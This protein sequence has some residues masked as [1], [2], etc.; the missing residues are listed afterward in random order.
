MLIKYTGGLNYINKYDDND[1]LLK[2]AKAGM[3]DNAGI[4]TQ[5]ISQFSSEEYVAQNKNAN[6]QL[7]YLAKWNDDP[8]RFCLAVKVLLSVRESSQKSRWSLAKSC[9]EM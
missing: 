1:M 7:P 9:H 8:K 4:V 3:P 5:V 2:A 6:I